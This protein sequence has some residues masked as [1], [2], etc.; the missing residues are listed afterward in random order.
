MP[1]S[2]AQGGSGPTC[3]YTI[4]KP[5][6]KCWE[7]LASNMGY[8]IFIQVFDYDLKIQS[9]TRRNGAKRSRVISLL[10][11]I[12]LKGVYVAS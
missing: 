2:W 10:H 6:C 12:K 3:I 1:M 8:N 4:R 9:Q 11:L 7:V 5:F